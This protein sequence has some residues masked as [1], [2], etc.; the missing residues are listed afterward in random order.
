VK[1]RKVWSKDPKRNAL[2]VQQFQNM[3]EE[4]MAVDMESQEYK[5]LTNSLT[6]IENEGMKNEWK[7][8]KHLGVDGWFEKNEGGQTP[9]V[10]RKLLQQMFKLE[11]LYKGDGYTYNKAGEKKTE[12]ILA[13]SKPHSELG[14]V[15]IDGAFPWAEK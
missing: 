5:D 12:E 6:V 11:G 7:N 15:A 10:A 14:V 13:E 1:S 3:Q 4:I 8:E 2:F 9:L